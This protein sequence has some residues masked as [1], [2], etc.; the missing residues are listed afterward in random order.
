M[1]SQ[2]VTPDSDLA[3]LNDAVAVLDT[4]W[5]ED[6][7]VPAGDLYPHQWSWDTA[8]IAIGRSWNDQERAQREIEHLFAA[9]WSDGMLP[10]IVFNPA[11]P[12]DAYFPGPTFWRSDRAVASPPGIATS[13][14]TQPPLH[15][16]AV[17]EIARNASD[18][19]AARQFLERMYP[20]LV[21]QHR[22][23]E[24]VRDVAGDG[25]SV[26]IHP[27]ESGMDNSPAWDEALDD[28]VI[29][30]GAVPPYARRDLVNAASS[31]RPTDAAYDRFVYLAATYRDAGY[32][33]SDLRRSCPFLVED[34][35]FNSV[36]I[37]SLDALADIA[38]AVDEDPAPFR[39]QAMRVSAALRR[40]LWDPAARQFRA[41]DI[42]DGELSS[43]GTI[44]SL[45][46]VI[47]H[48]LPPSM[49]TAI[50]RLLDHPDFRPRDDPDHF[51]VASFDLRARGFD[52]RRYWRGPIWINTDWLLWRGLT[53]HGRER[54]AGEIADSMLGLVRR[55]G[56]H[57]YFSPFGGQG[58]GS[59]DFSWTAALI[60]DLLHRAKRVTAQA[61]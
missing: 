25:L 56:W 31:D 54:V 39:D 36:R 43:V 57:E 2:G 7:T 49:V 55:S 58:Y 20:R 50:T 19:R 1:W 46:P 12:D 28:L 60:I 41:R 34:P 52:P 29:A 11:V 16:V 9:Q 42:R 21:A 26:I 15:A 5:R 4:N 3:L 59:N 44:T 24:T 37:W 32:D 61:R 8:F 38:G 48:R 45:S 27:W 53:A 51:M 14:L 40:H 17:A 6:H 23:L 18:R 13:G 47:D 22:Y 30:A 33:Q 35:L 10:H